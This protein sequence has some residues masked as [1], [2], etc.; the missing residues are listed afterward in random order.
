MP[1]LNWNSP[2][3]AGWVQLSTSEHPRF[4]MQVHLKL[5]PEALSEWREGL[6]EVLLNARGE[7]KL[8][9]PQGWT[10]YFKAREGETRLL[11]AHPEQDAWVATV[12]VSS[13]SSQLFLDRLE[14]LVSG[15]EGFRLSELGPPHFVSNL[16]VSVALA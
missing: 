10:I 7:L 9:L 4:G 12:A 8:E 16:E 2:S 1:Y 5:S 13:D 15:S 3:T 14:S 11:L 6:K